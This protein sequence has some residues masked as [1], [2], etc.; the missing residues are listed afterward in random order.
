MR[1]IQRC[2]KEEIVVDRG[3]VKNQKLSVDVQPCKSPPEKLWVRY[4]DEVG[5]HNFKL[6]LDDDD[7]HSQDED[8][9]TDSSGTKIESRILLLH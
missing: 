1:W 2:E 6:W 9:D 5:N 7:S 3:L 8:K 4:F